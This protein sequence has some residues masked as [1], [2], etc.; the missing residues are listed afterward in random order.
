MSGCT[1]GPFWSVVPPD[2][3]PMHDPER[4][5]WRAKYL[6][7]FGQSRGSFVTTGTNLIALDYRGGGA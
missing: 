7:E 5:Y 2:P 6:A 4:A 1:C 3:C